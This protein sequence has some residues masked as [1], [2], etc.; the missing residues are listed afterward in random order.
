MFAKALLI[1]P[2]L[3]SLLCAGPVAPAERTVAPRDPGACVGMA[4]LKGCCTSPGCCKSAQQQHA[5]QA[6]APLTAAPEWQPVVLSEQAIAL[7]Q[8]RPALAQVFIT[9][10]ETCGGHTLPPLVTS[11]I[12]LI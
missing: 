11:C 7:L 6:P 10:D 5:P 8:M 9:V 3:L 4:C 12:Q 2:L 1:L